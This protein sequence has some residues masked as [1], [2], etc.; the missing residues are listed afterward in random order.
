MESAALNVILS[1]SPAAR[2]LP[3]RTDTIL[4]SV[5]SACILHCYSDHWGE[6][7]DV[8]PKS[9]LSVF[10]FIL[11]SAGGWGG[12]RARIEGEVC[13]HRGGGVRIEGREPDQESPAHVPAPRFGITPSMHPTPPHST[14]LRKHEPSPAA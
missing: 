13:A 1:K 14:P 3:R 5:A 12:P 10:D 9:Y 11:G 4:F 2:L 6:R 8:I 7:R